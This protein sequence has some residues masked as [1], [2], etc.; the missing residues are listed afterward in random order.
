MKHTNLEKSPNAQALAANLRNELEGIAS[1]LYLNYQ[2]EDTEPPQVVHALANDTLSYLEAVETGTVSCGCRQ[3]VANLIRI[4]E[5]LD[6]VRHGDECVML[7][8][9]IRSMSHYGL[10]IDGYELGPNR[11]IS[12]TVGYSPQR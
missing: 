1:D 2:G 3:G 7:H 10:S 6:P 11:A 9:I 4:T 5:E 8:D 12:K